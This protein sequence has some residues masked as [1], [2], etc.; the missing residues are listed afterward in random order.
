[1]LFLLDLITNGMTIRN[2]V[3]F[4]LLMAVGNV[5][6]QATKVIPDTVIKMGGRK[7]P[8]FIK[9]VGSN[10]IIYSFESKPDSIIK[11]QRKDLEKIIYKNGRVE[12]FSKPAVQM[13][14]EGQWESILVTRKE[15]DVSGLYKRAF[16]T[17]KSTGSARSKKA[18]QETATIRLQKK[19]ATHGGTIV[20]I[21]DEESI[22]AYG[23]VPSYYMEGFVYGTKPL[24][25][26]TNVV[27]DKDK[28]PAVK[29]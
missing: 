29:R 18:A 7:F 2:F 24:E 20:L 3:L 19:A 6:G 10:F 26:G 5:F 28:K 11:A 25:E 1:M 21:T 14:Q 4:F 27:E 17:A 15:K 9:T 16:I 8:A 13:I 22:G 23:D 12:I